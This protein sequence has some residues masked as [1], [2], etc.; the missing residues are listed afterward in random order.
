MKIIDCFTYFNEIDLLKIRLELL[1][2]HVDGF[3]ISEANITHSGVAKPYNLE[4]HVDELSAWRDKIF[5]I[6]YAPDLTG[7]DFSVKEATFNTHSAAWQVERGQRDQMALYARQFM[8]D[9]VFIVSDLDELPNPA[10]IDAIRGRQL[11]FDAARLEMSMHYYY[12]NC[13]GIG[14]ENARWYQGFAAKADQLLSEKTLSHFRVTEQMPVIQNAGWH[15]SYIGGVQSVAEKLNATAHTELNT[16]EI[17]NLHHLARCIELG[18]D[19]LGR[20]GHD[21]AFLPIDRFP[22]ALAQLM[23]RNPTLIKTS[24]V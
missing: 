13:I 4:A 14:K 21:Y 2:P 24:M 18:I 11:Q 5:Y 22:P 10:V 20:A 3:C 17:N 8:P 1:Y 16:P 12:M 7:L 19:H 6:K 15:F 23:W 9:D